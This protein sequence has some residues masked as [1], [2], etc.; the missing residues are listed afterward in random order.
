MVAI[1]SVSTLDIAKFEGSEDAGTV[2]TYTITRTG[3][4]SSAGSVHWNL[5]DGPP[6]PV[7]LG[8][9]EEDTP[10]TGIANFAIGVASVTLSFTVL[11]DTD[12]EPN[13]GFG[14]NIFNPSGGDLIGTDIAFSVIKDDD[15][16][17][18]LGTS[19]NDKLD[20][21]A[22]AKGTVSDF[23]QGGK[24]TVIGSALDDTVL[25]GTAVTNADQFDGGAGFDRIVL[26]GDY[27][28]GVTLAFATLVNVEEIDFVDG[29]SYK[30][31][32]VDNT[33]AQDA[34]LIIDA[35]SLSGA[36]NATVNGVAETSGHITFIGGAG[37][38]VFRGGRA[39]DS[40]AGG[41]GADRLDG[42]KG[43]DTFIY[44]EALDSPLVTFGGVIQPS[45]DDTLVS[46]QVGQDKIDLAAFGLL[47]SQTAVWTKSTSGFSADLSGATGFF[48]TT[49]SAVA[50]EYARSGG[51]ARLYVD[52]NTNGNLDAGDMM[53]QLTGVGRG[54]LNGTS[55]IF[56]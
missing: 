45:F 12:A 52:V 14:V 51:N 38:D 19:R 47:G 37:D 18:F 27:T 53:I 41:Y 49:G 34:T 46:F 10:R 22:S 11:G 24:D 3:D 28:W 26:T 43:A 5:V 30:I 54:S 33:I 1:Y 4:L 50:A 16:L 44:D 31:N 25:Y 6:A 17:H 8:D 55:F 15:A 48:G 9:F 39:S 42:F 29:F 40:V 20:L 32:L 13:E 2:F 7:T 35:R 21:T 56:S 36:N 23:S